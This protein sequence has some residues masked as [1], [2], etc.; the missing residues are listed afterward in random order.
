VVVVVVVV[1]GGWLQ[2]PL[3]L[4]MSNTEYSNNI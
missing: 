4:E 2:E 3:G 1:V